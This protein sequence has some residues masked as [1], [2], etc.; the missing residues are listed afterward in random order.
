MISESVRS[1]RTKKVCDLLQGS[2]RDITLQ[3]QN[4]EACHENETHIRL[5]LEQA[6]RNKDILLAL[7]M[8]CVFHTGQWK[9]S[10]APW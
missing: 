3:Q 9:I 8:R 1:V 4:A 5:L 10:L 6:E 2:V 7:L